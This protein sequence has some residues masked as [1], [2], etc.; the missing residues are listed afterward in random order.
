MVNMGYVADSNPVESAHLDDGLPSSFSP[1]SIL[2]PTYLLKYTP[3]LNRIESHLNLL[4]IQVDISAGSE[5]II[6]TV[7]RID[8]LDRRGLVM[9]I[10]VLRRVNGLLIVSGR[11]RGLIGSG[12]AGHRGHVAGSSRGRRRPTRERLMM[13]VMLMQVVQVRGGRV[14]I[15][16]DRLLVLPDY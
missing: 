2:K 5:K 13:L 7:V 16:S 12:E 9:M 6:V 8:G 4:A 15:I 10:V 14:E 3:L 11:L 1:K